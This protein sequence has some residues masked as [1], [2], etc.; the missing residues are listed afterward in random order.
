MC[1]HV[2]LLPPLSDGQLLPQ[3]IPVTHQSALGKM[4]TELFISKDSK[5]TYGIKKIN[6]YV[7]IKQ[8]CHR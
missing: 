1:Q 2:N 8:E 7:A 6:T 5:N 4:D 3:T